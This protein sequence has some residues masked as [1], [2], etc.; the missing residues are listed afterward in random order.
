M[1]RRLEAMKFQDTYPKVID[2]AKDE[3]EAHTCFQC[4]KEN[5][6]LFEADII[7]QRNKRG[8]IKFL[9][10]R[11][12]LCS[13][14]NQLKFKEAKI[15]FLPTYK[16]HETKGTFSLEKKMKGRL[17]GYADRIIFNGPNLSPILYTSLG[18]KGNDHLPIFGVFRFHGPPR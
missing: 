12:S 17:P 16:R 11:D 7:S 8:L 13:L 5:K 1:K 14:K 6:L 15:D 10:E 9:I 18:V 2:R 3:A 4:I